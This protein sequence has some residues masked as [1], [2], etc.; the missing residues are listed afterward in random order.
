MRLSLLQA[1]L[2]TLGL[3]GCSSASRA[4]P[5]GDRLDVLTSF[6]LALSKYDFREAA[7]YLPPADRAKLAGPE[8]G[9][10]PEYRN[11]VRAIRRTTLLNNPLI[12]VRHGLIYGIPD[13]LPV[14]AVGEMDTLGAGLN[15]GAAP[16]PDNPVAA[17][18]DSSGI[19]IREQEGLKKVADAFFR[20]VSRR[21]WKKAMTYV[22]ERERGNFLDGKGAVNGTA[23][24]RLTAVDTAQWEALTLKDGKLTGVVL[25]IPDRKEANRTF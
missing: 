21:E 4:H 3:A 7:T 2:V 6:S 12:E 23:R 22:D 14:L 16:A 10:L 19:Q 20:A 9:I 13:L 17:L 24:R 11:R 18:S 5:D 8:G 1:L 25:I 15:A